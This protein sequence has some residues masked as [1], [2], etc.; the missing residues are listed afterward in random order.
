MIRTQIQLTEEQ[1]T[2]L[3][4]LAASE[5]VSMAELVRRGVELLLGARDPEA[6]AHLRQRALAAAGRFA[7]G[8][9]DLAE[10]HDHYLEQAFDDRAGMQAQSGAVADSSAA[11][12]SRP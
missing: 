4:Q 1:A 3:R 10:A 5:G 11:K 12:E 9:G 8:C 6:D 7:S 2:T